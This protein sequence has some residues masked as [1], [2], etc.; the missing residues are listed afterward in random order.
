MK[1]MLSRN[2]NSFY[3]RAVHLFDE[4]KP[5]HKPLYMMVEPTN[6]CNLSCPLCPTGNDSLRAPRGYMDLS[7]YKKLIDELSPYIKTLLMWGF[8]EPFLHADILKMF[9]YASEKRIITKTSTNGQCFGG[10]SECMELVKSGIDQIRVSLDGLSNDTLRVYRKGASIDA[11]IS[12]LENIT[13]AKRILRTEKPFILIQ[14][15]VMK[16]NEHERSGLKDFANRYGAGFRFKMVSTS[17]ECETCDEDNFIPSDEAMSRYRRVY[18]DDGST[19]LIPK[20][21]KPKLCPYPWY[22]A[23]ICWDGDVVPCCKDPHREHVL[24]NAFME[25]GLLKVWNG[26]RYLKFREVYLNNP[27]NHARCKKCDHVFHY[28]LKR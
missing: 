6:L 9:S 13:Q 16:H 24:G 18:M 26:P 7:H 11:I 12:G 19:R 5:I 27:M 25:G 3:A 22:W 14:F 21:R 8:G 2:V 10:R 28:A 4:T 1:Y 17:T 15:I 20:Y 23:H